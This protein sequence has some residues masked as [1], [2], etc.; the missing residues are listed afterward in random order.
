MANQVSA[1]AANKPVLVFAPE[2]LNLA[3]VTRTLQIAK[4]AARSFE[5]VFTSYDSRGRNHSFIEQ[6]GFRIIP[7]QPQLSDASIELFWKKNRGE[8][9]AEDYFSEQGLCA[10][11][12]SERA[13]YRE[14]KPRAVITGFCLSTALSARAAGIP[15]VWINQ[16]TWLSE[17]FEKWAEWPDA[18]DSPA[19]RLLPDRIRDRLAKWAT[20]VT[21]WTMNRGFNRVAKKLGVGRFTGSALLEGDHNL[22]AEPPDFSGLEVPSRLSGRHTF[23]GPLLGGLPLEVPQAVRDLPRDRPIVY[24]AM[25]SSGVEDL[26]V[27]LV[28]AFAD[29][30]YRVIAPVGPLVRKQGIRP[31]DN[32]VVT[33]WLPA[34]EVNPMADVSVVHGGIGTLMT[35][36]AAGTP[37]VAIPNGNPEQECNVQCLVR[38]GIAVQLH[39]RRITE[40]DVL[41]AIDRALA[42]PVAKA[43][44][45]EFQAS[46][47][48]MNGPERAACFLEE[49][50]A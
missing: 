16:T 1:V 42:D 22:F 30:P 37:I 5:C 17:Y 35:A 38:K 11:V 21:F 9:L 48:A 29:R 50:F 44:A 3:E 49:R 18:I 20:P 33:D 26:I 14:L 46:V 7:L 12:E 40:A 39:Q 4:V 28:A 19:S 27:R 25:G 8:G 24:F 43:K 47:L 31:P 2:S 32:V 10:R 6:A 23:I 15:L 13:L 41:A 36:C 45:R 34:E